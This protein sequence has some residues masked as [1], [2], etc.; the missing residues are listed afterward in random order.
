MNNS[1]GWNESA[2]A[3]V[4]VEY[5]QKSLKNLSAQETEWLNELIKEESEHDLDRPI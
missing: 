3:R 1:N 5:W 2:T 4:R